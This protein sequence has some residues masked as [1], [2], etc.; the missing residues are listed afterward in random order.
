M[1][2]GNTIIENQHAGDILVSIITPC[3]NSSRHIEEMIN[4]VLQQTFKHWELIIVDN[5]SSDNSIEIVQ[6]F[7]LEDSRIKL[8]YSEKGAAIARQKGI[9]AAK[10]KYISFLDADDLWH[11]EKLHEQVNFM[12]KNDIKF[13][14]HPYLYIDEVG[15]ELGKI[16]EAP[17]KISYKSQL[18]GN[19]IGCLSVM[20]LRE[21]ARD[22]KIPN[23]RKRNDAALWLKILKELDYGCRLNTNLAYYRVS[24]NSLSSG[25]KLD[26]LK[27]HFELYRISEK[28]STIKSLYYVM[29]NIIVFIDI[30]LRMI[31]RNE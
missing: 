10:G 6:S 7:S 17:E 25:S 15:N 24:D 11:K 26:L 4:S 9:E 28:F 14:Y 19:R 16:R 5:G 18:K 22:T 2:Q 27:Y 31:K 13:C 1:V 23:L 30:Q 3:Y 12:E 21:A 20:Y 8:K 29:W